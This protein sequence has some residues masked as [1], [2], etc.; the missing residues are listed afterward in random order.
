MARAYLGGPWTAC[1]GGHAIVQAT[2]MHDGMAVA[3]GSHYVGPYDLP[4]LPSE[5]RR[6]CALQRSLPLVWQVYL[7]QTVPVC[8]IATI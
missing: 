7:Q 1:T 5:A 6:I 3:C 4:A 8:Y 2:A